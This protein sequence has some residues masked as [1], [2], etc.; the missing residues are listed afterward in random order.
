MK[1]EEKIDIQKRIFNLF[2]LVNDL[3]FET[4]KIYELYAYVL[5]IFIEYNIM[6]IE[7]LENIFK[8]ST[9]L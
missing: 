7:D 5:Y 8:N 6:K 3:A 9:E 1:E 2:E 4:P